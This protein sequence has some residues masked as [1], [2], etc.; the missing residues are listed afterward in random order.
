[1]NPELLKMLGHSLNPK[2]YFHDLQFSGFYVPT[3][4][5]KISYNLVDP[6]PFLLHF[7]FSGPCTFPP[8][9]PGVV[10]GPCEPRERV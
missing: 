4:H 2:L 7:F 9:L 5:C 1:M 10:I 3:P 6:A 8:P